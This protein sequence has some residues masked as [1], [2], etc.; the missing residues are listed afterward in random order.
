MRN[1]DSRKEGLCQWPMHWKEVLAL[2]G[3]GGL[4]SYCGLNVMVVDYSHQCGLP[5]LPNFTSD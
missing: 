1:K 5:T 2:S 3:S 4:H